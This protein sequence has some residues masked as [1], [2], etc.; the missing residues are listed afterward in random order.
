MTRAIPANFQRG[1]ILSGRKLLLVCPQLTLFLCSFKRC[2]GSL[3]TPSQMIPFSS[4]VCLFEAFTRVSLIS[5]LIDSG[6]GG[7]TKD[8]D[9]DEADGHDE[10]ECFKSYDEDINLISLLK[11]FTL[12]V[13]PILP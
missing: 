8:L 4:T 5:S 1:T 9:G 6:H 2:N 12:L 11:S 10:G 7:Q 3:A 13:Y